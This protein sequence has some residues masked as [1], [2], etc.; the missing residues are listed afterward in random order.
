MF[1]MSSKRPGIL[2]IPCILV[3]VL[4]MVTGMS[5]HNRRRLYLYNKAL[6]IPYIS[7]LSAASSE[8]PPTQ[9][10][11]FGT[12][13][14]CNG[15]NTFKY[16][17]RINPQAL[18]K[19]NTT[20]MIVA[21]TSVP[22]N[23]AS[24][25]M[26]RKTWSSYCKRDSKWVRCVFLMGSGYTAAEQAIVDQEA[27]TYG[28][29]L[30]GDFVDC[31]KNI[32]LKVN[33]AMHWC[34]HYCPSVPFFH[35]AADD[36]Y[37]NI[38]EVLYL[39]H[40]NF[41]DLYNTMAGVIARNNKRVPVNLTKYPNFYYPTHYLGSTFLLGREM[42]RKILI[43]IPDVPFFHM[44]NIYYGLVVEQLG[45]E[46]VSLPGFNENYIVIKDNVIKQWYTI[47]GVDP[48]GMQ[49]IW[50]RERFRIGRHMEAWGPLTTR[51]PV[52]LSE[53]RSSKGPNIAA[54]SRRKGNPG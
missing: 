6:A 5:I 39:I 51:R 2:T 35:R 28:D 48:L 22:G 38:P 32:S 10:I 34:Q 24:R 50:E 26:I 20:T 14:R 11:L 18:C 27:D 8:S 49:K 16:I 46:M 40:N 41:I 52:V 30:Q 13:I 42:M 19:G 1:Y 23:G 17:Y 45:M 3:I 44:E 53:K 12:N 54:T 47:C 15:C 33:M 25:E 36:T 31:D 29:I 9:S 37:I 7:P 43:K 4:L 21:I